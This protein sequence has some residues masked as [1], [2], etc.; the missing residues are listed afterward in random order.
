[1]VLALVFGVPQSATVWGEHEQLFDEQ[2]G[3]AADELYPVV[4]GLRL[5]EAR[6]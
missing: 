3:E 6:S 5:K 2:D 4:V 1:M